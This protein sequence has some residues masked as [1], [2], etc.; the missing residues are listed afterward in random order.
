MNDYPW[1][2]S[3]ENQS[4]KQTG[5]AI[6]VF[7]CT[8]ALERSPVRP[9]VIKID[10]TIKSKNVLASLVPQSMGTNFLA[11]FLKYM[12][13]IDTQPPKMPASEPTSLKPAT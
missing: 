6:T 2:Y 7:L 9:S 5:L 4:K 12:N 10:N 3:R 13:L 8:Y 1:N 11:M